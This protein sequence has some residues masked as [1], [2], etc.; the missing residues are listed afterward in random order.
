MKILRIL[1]T[2]YAAILF[3]A[4][5]LV[6]GLFIVLPVLLSPKGGKLSIKF[7]RYWAGIWSFLC[8]IRYEIYGKENID[9]SQPYIYIFNHR[10][11]LDAPIIP[12]AIPQEIR[13]LGKKELSKIP[14][15]G[16]IVGRLAV[17]VDRSDAESRKNSV[18][19][20]VGIL[21]K[22]ISIVVAPEG[23]RNN[24][25]AELLPFQKGAFR[26]S[27]ETGIPIMP[28]IVLGADKLMQRGSLLLR[29]GKVRIYFSKAMNPPKASDS[30]VNDFTMNCRSRLEAMILTHE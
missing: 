6:F 26:L 3:V 7:I 28:L 19:K 17:W 2:C 13:A 14:V 5:M 21:E 27:V 25:D 8:G 16:Q 15:F 29:P 30:A 20:L 11:F 9:P 23:T 4:L 1:Y 12:I 24:T 10:S 22:G 18:K